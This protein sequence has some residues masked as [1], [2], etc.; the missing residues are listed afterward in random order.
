MPEPERR[1]PEIYVQP[2]ESHLVHAAH[3]AA[4]R[5]RL[6]R[7]SHVSGSRLG[8]GALCH[9]MMPSCPPAQRA[10]LTSVPR[11]RYVDFA[12]REMARLDSLGARSRRSR[13]EVVWRQRCLDGRR[14]RSSAD[15][16]QAELGSGPRRARRKKDSQWPPVAWAAPRA[17]TSLSRPCTAKFGCAG[18]IL[19]RRK[20][21]RNVPRTAH[22]ANRR[23]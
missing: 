18:S 9:P 21:V 17:C 16:R 13:G 5:A 4:H 7:R 3:R 1:L 6:L 15:H 19:A 14:Q 22:R 12:I 8:I 23:R 2:G 20:I 11:R 10:Q